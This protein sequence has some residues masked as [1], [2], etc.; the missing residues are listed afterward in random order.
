[1]DIYDVEATRQDNKVRFTC[2]CQAGLLGQVCK[3]RTALLNGDVTSVVNGASEVER[4]RE[5]VRGSKIEQRLREVAAL[6][7]EMEALKRQLT[8]TKKAYGRE[9]A[10]GA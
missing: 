4:L 10:E 8:A 5:L 9:M 7:A 2:T 3:H 6:E 1:G